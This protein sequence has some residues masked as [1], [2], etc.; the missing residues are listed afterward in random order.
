MTLQKFETLGVRKLGKEEVIDPTY[1]GTQD[2]LQVGG[3]SNDIAYCAACLL[4]GD[5]VCG[6][7][8]AKNLDKYFCRKMEKGS[9]G[10]DLIIPQYW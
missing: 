4:H 2:V 3:A 5:H 9:C 7:E 10:G 6:W 1:L 8:I